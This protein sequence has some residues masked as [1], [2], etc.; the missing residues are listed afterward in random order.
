MTEKLTNLKTLLKNKI[1][2]KKWGTT[3]A[4]K[5]TKIRNDLKE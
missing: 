5:S 3:V 2:D 4:F 1:S